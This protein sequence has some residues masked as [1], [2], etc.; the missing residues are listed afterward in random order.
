[1]RSIAPPQVAA[2]AVYESGLARR[3]V[4]R[5]S[6]RSL[7][8]LAC[9]K[10]ARMPLRGGRVPKRFRAKKSR[11]PIGVLLFLVRETGLEPVRCE[12]HAPQTCASASS[13]TPAYHA[14]LC[15]TLVLYT[16]CA[17]KSIPFLKKV[18]KNQIFFLSHL[19]CVQDLRIRS[20]FFICSSKQP[21]KH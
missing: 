9:S 2:F 19:V 10:K 16:F 14:L 8:L 11:T 4:E 3:D 5:R 1:M 17:K 20:R 12:P 15:A 13:A 6:L 21:M 18:L 7:C